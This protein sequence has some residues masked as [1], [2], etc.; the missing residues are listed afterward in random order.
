MR[1]FALAVLL[2]AAA[3]TSCSFIGEGMAIEFEN[4]TDK[5]L[6]V[7]LDYEIIDDAAVLPPELKKG[8]VYEDPPEDDFLLII[9][10]AD[11]PVI[12]CRSLTEKEAT[13]DSIIVDSLAPLAPLPPEC[14]WPR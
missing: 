1:V 4:Q 3:S 14:A 5:T 10:I 2:I 8:F 11:G 12:F 9:R 6:E 13:G 7:L